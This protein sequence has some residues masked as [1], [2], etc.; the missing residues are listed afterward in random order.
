MCEVGEDGSLTI[1]ILGDNVMI[2]NCTPEVRRGQR[3]QMEIIPLCLTYRVV[4]FAEMY[5]EEKKKE[6]TI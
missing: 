2:Q 1:Y 3:L 5:K 4:I 6:H